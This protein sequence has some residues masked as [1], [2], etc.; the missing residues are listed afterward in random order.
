VELA[1]QLADA[2]ADITRRYF[3]TRVPVDVKADASPVTI[4]DREAEAAVRALITK[5]FPQHAIFGEEQGFSAG[6]SG[7]SEYLW[8]IDPVDGTKSFI[9]GACVVGAILGEGM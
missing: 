2:A 9:T 3:R 6:S 4:A 5:A 7:D 1:N 8:V